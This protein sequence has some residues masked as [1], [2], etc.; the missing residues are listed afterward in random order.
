[1]TLHVLT[2]RLGL[3][4]PDYLDVSLQGNLR[5]GE[6]GEEPHRGIGLFF[7]PSPALLYPYL[8]KRR[9]GQLTDADWAA[10]SKGYRLEMRTSYRRHHLAWD[11]LLSW[12]RVVL[13][14]F[15]TDPERCHR[16]LLAGILV[17]L[18]AID[19]GEVLRVARGAARGAA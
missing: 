15:C 2:A 10:Y 8:S 7:A 1:M 18:G 19:C 11:R 5:R 4:D 6:A 13:L 14:C 9:S 17:Q 12:E 3:R 16:R